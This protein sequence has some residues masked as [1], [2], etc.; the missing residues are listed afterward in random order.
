MGARIHLSQEGQW[1]LSPSLA[2]MAN[3]ASPSSSCQDLLTRVSPL[4]DLW[5]ELYP[6][7]LSEKEIPW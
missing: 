2:F 4:I 7:K 1:H 5:P 6:S 3:L